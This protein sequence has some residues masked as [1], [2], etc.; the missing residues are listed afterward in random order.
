MISLDA[1]I[2]GLLVDLDGTMYLGDRLLDG[3]RDFARRIRESGRKAL[4]LSNNSSRSRSSYGEKLRRLGVD[5]DDSEIFI[6]TNAAATYLRKE[7]PGAAVF[8]LGTP[9]LIE[10]LHAEGIR[11]DEKKPGVVLLGFDKTI[12]YDKIRRAYDLLERGLPYVATHPDVLCPVDGGFVPDTGC[13]I[14]MFK[15]ATGRVP[16]IAGKPSMLMARCA[17]EELGIGPSQAAM[18]GDRL[19]TDMRMAR[20]AGL[21]SVLVLSGETKRSDLDASEIKPDCVVEGVGDIGFEP[22]T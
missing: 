13:F 15:E 5:A 6:S 18:V 8:P 12:T 4:Y 9:E 22:A 14:A 11:T 7:H 17:L 3:A 21:K 2:R 16:V 10:E 19:Y 20:D 1:G